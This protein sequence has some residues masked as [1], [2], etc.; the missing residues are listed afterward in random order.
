MSNQSPVKIG[1]REREMEERGHDPHD[2]SKARDPIAP[3][4]LEDAHEKD[5]Q[6]QGTPKS[7]LN[8]DE[9]EGDKDKPEASQPKKTNQ[10]KRK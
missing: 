7:D 5:G 10:S 8:R 3:S 2:G 4:D 6:I 9:P 1:D